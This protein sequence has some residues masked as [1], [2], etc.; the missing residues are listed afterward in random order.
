L[1]AG[2]LT[3]LVVGFESEPRLAASAQLARDGVAAEDVR[4]IVLSHLHADHAA[5]LAAFPKATVIV[6]K[7]EWEDQKRRA[8]AKPGP[9]EFD[10]AA[11][12]PRL[13]LRLVDL[14]GEQPYGAF[15]HGVDLFSDGAVILTALPG[16]T[17][18][19]MGAWVNLD[20][21][22]VMLAG[23]AAWVVDN[24]MDLALPHARG[25]QDPAAYRRS[26]EM[27]RAMQA[28]MPRLVIFPGHDLTPR[29][30]SD[31]TDLPLSEPPAAGAAGPR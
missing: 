3:G 28:A 24:V 26:L 31:R 13:R 23:D 9:K 18:G 27:L 22:P 30:L 7:R 10:P 4:W 21:G 20:G 19:S 2:A 25:M 11:W 12:E 29:K 6:S 14:E 8:A 17:A 5:D 16:H 15:D 1:G